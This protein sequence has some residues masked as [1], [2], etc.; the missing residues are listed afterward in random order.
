M[1]VLVVCEHDESA[2]KLCSYMDALGFAVEGVAV[3]GDGFSAKESLDG[4][5]VTWRVSLP[6]K[7]M[8]EDCAET[9]LE[10]VAQQDYD[11]VVFESTKRCKVVAGKIAAGL[12]M[13][14]MT[15]V[16]GISA[17]KSVTRMVYGGAAIRSEKAIGK[18]AIIV[19]DSAV[20]GDIEIGVGEGEVRDLPFVE[21]RVS[22]K[23]VESSAKAKPTVDLSAAKVIIG[24]GRGVARQED[25][26]VVRRFA[27]SVG[28]DI[29]CTRP[30]A[31]GEKWL[32]RETYIGVS[33]LML[34]PDVYIALGV[35]GQIQ[36]MVGI[37]KA[38]VVFSVNKDKNAMVF[39][40]SDYG[41]VSDLYKVLPS[42]V[43]RFAE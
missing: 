35:S 43:S 22:V 2:A 30:I 27:N 16:V 25:I 34:S 40:Q 37:N 20:A 36:H 38:K 24:I 19:M 21:P 8:F 13:S 32:P 31:E 1:K 15:D 33:G 41:I 17:D 28:A 6:E 14:A 10:F 42:L 26:A 7:S 18:T 5:Q 4:M 11:A 29:G 23:K 39:E 9:V 12:G 3:K